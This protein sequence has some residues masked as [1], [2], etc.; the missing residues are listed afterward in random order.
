MVVRLLRFA[1]PLAVLLALVP[2]AAHAS[3]NRLPPPA[4]TSPTS[5]SVVQQNGSLVVSGTG[6][7]G[8]LVYVGV[9]ATLATY[10][11]VQ[12]QDEKDYQAFE[13]NHTF[14]GFGGPPGSIVAANGTWTAVVDRSRIT[15]AARKGVVFVAADQVSHGTAGAGQY[16]IS[17]GSTAVPVQLAWLGRP[18]A[19]QFVGLG[20]TRT[21]RRQA[22]GTLELH[23][24]GVP[25]AIVL[26]FVDSTAAGMAADLNRFVQQ[27]QTLG[28]ACPQG[29]RFCSTVA[30]SGAG[31]WVLTVDAGTARSARLVVAAA[32]S[33]NNSSNERWSVAS[34]PLA[35]AVVS[36]A[37][38]AVS[39]PSVFS[40]LVAF[41]WRTFTPAHVALTAGAALVLT[42][43]LGVPTTL[44]NSALETSYDER[45][46]RLKPVTDLLAR[47]LRRVRAQFGA[48][49]A[50]WPRWIFPV[51]W[52]LVASV[53]AGFADPTFGF[54][55]VSLRLLLSLF[56]AFA[57]LNV[58]GAY[59]TW[60]L[61]ASTSHTRRPTFPS[62]PSNIVI[63]AATVIVA[64]LIHL[65]PTL[66]F[67]T[68]LGL[69]FG[70]KLALHRKIRVILVG[71]AYSAVVGLLAWFAYSL[72]PGG[73]TDFGSVLFREFFSQLTV[74]GLATLPIALLPFRSLNGE[75]IFEW[76][77]ILWAFCYGIGMVLFLLVLLPMPFSWAG[78]SEPLVAWIL[79]FVAYSI[80]AIL[81]WCGVRFQWISAL[82]HRH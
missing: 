38:P 12:A 72:V 13:K 3:E 62:R 50:A 75:T 16:P 21:V 34:T 29:N 80:I 1:V 53:I 65:E 60:W 11:A 63:L 20:S 15:A 25:G 19:P 6:T 27:E 58:L 23:G 7:P 14:G 39:A 64:R 8:A 77:R 78:V 33:V 43:L 42:L 10:T 61:T 52:F 73:A 51:A 59:V 44:L 41:D 48:A 17:H 71:L 5:T 37:S 66:V 32:Q 30:V 69:D 28:T 79:L 57:V 46:R 67:G 56:V 31:T 70:V 35:V 74:G 76:R 26:G 68:V 45:S 82:A 4:I 2:Q 9:Y 47:A 22:D 18:P 54:N 55:L 49:T 24:T 40:Q 36:A 81:V